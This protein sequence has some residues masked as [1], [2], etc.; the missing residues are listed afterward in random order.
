MAALA[1]PPC[2]R[3]RQTW[4]RR[5]CCL[6]VPAVFAVATCWLAPR[7]RR[8]L[9]FL[10]GD[11]VGRRRPALV[12]A[13]AL[14]EEAPEVSLDEHRAMRLEKLE[15]LREEGVNPYAYSYERTHTAAEL[16]GEYAGME[17]G[18]EDDIADVSV[19]GRLMA[20]RTMGKLAFLSLQ[21]H[22]GTIQL[23]VEQKRL[24][25]EFKNI[26]AW[27]NTGDMIGGRGSMRRTKKGELSVNIREWSMLSKSL[28]PL[29]D[30]W[31]GLTDVETRYRQRHLDMIANPAV[32]ETFR[33][34]ARLTSSLRRRLDDAGFLEI[35]TPVLHECAGGASAKPFE[36]YH[37]ALKMPLTLRIATELHLK[38]LIIGGFDRVYEVGRIFRNEGLSIRHN[39]EFTS[40]ELYQAYADYHTMMD[41]TEKL[42]SGLAQELLGTMVVRYGEVEVD[43]TPP[44]RRAT[45][46]ELVEEKS[47]FDFASPA[48]SVQE[49]KDAALRAGVGKQFLENCTS[50]GQIVSEAFEAL[51]EADLVQPTF[52]L[53]YP[54]EISP[55][56]KAHRS[57]S[58]LTERFELFIVGR[59]LANAYSELTDPIEQRRRFE[60]QALQRAMGD[61]EAC[62]VDEDFLQAMEQGM[63]PTGGLGIG[64]DR[65]VMLLTNSQTIRDVIA[66]P[67]LRK[68]V[69][70]VKRAAEGEPGS[71]RG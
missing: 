16:Q 27:T 23:F 61:E 31:N 33:F 5:S 40:V 35:E 21:D 26:L 68:E 45:M 69:R 13:A 37:N 15:V 2:G 52:V 36:T 11:V 20:K 56:A 47:G 71:E 65:L 28:L 42:I 63:P 25:A 4:R 43:L 67:Q 39:P 66:F 14:A 34:R 17:D 22:T 51:C 55:L 53:D 48:L 59:E 3:Q 30:K 60:A 41:L 19:A 49:A 8:A 58:G 57:K 46:H 18:G 62:E 54:V 29:P 24:G 10:G 64:I 38:R 7:H 70:E 9:A 32:R 1:G 6:L 50:V 12:A 44:W